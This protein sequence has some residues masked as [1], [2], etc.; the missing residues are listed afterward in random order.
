MPRQKANVFSLTREQNCTLQILEH[1]CDLDAAMKSVH[2]TCAVLLLPAFVLRL[3]AY[4]LTQLRVIL[5]CT[6]G[7]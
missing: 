6:S 7:E 1:T 3:H 5:T 2:G 4:Q